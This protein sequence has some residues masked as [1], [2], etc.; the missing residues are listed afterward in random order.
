LYKQN[1]LIIS[2][3][4]LQEIYLFTNRSLARISQLARTEINYNHSREIENFKFEE[5]HVCLMNSRFSMILHT[6]IMNTKM[7]IH[8]ILESSKFLELSCW[9]ALEI[10]IH[11]MRIMIHFRS[12]VQQV[13]NKLLRIVQ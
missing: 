10:K 8:K 5:F 7:K 1:L 12:Q 4:K 3:H 6:Q 9:T 13:H 11:Q 2:L